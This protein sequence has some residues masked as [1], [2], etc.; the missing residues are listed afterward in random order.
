MRWFHWTV[1]SFM[2]SEWELCCAVAAF[3]GLPV[4]AGFLTDSL[5]SSLQRMRPFLHPVWSAP[6]CGVLRLCV[7]LC[8]RTCTTLPMLC[9]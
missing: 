3:G 8:C 1:D 4:L 7:V 9:R 5:R 6:L 2:V